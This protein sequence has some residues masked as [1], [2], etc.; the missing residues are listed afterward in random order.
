M[1]EWIGIALFFAACA[2]VNRWAFQKDVE[3]AIRWRESRLQQLDR[4]AHKSV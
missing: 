1:A 4:A 2:V 3:R